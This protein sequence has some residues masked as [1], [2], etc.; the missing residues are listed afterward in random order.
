MQKDERIH[1]EWIL[2][3]SQMVQ[4]VDKRGLVT[5][6]G[7]N[8]RPLRIEPLTEERGFLSGFESL[9]EAQSMQRP[10]RS[11][12]LL[13]ALYMAHGLRKL[14]ITNWSMCRINWRALFS[15]ERVRDPREGGEH[16]QD[17]IEVR[18]GVADQRL[19][20]IRCAR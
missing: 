1:A 18:H 9:N 11:A 14:P 4:H 16:A 8:P 3:R 17:T 13:A 20:M 19:I 12:D 7:L 15:H 6:S 10:A 2:L 5:G